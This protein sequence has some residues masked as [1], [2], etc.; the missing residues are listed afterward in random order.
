MR[1]A[2]ALLFVVALP[3]AADFRDYR[4]LAEDPAL[5]QGLASIAN[6]TLAENPNL[7]RENLSMTLIDLG[8]GRRASF[9]P[10]VG[11]HPASVVKLF[12]LSA[13]YERIRTGRLRRSSELDRAMRDMIVDSA[14]D[15]TSY[16]IDAISGVSSGPELA[17]R[18]FRRWKEKREWVTRFFA[19]QGYDI[20]AA[21]K[22]WAEGPYGR[23]VQLL[24][25][26]R[27][28]RNRISSEQPA[29]LI[30][31]IVNGRA[32]SKKASEEMLALMS[33]DVDAQKI[34][35]GDNQVKEFLGESLPAGSKLWSKAGWTSEVRHDA[36]L[37]ELPNG[38]RF[39]AVVLTRGD[40]KN[41]ALLPSIGRKLVALFQ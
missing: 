21:G 28:T 25:A 34:A 12:F 10:E 37:V 17:G 32:V 26:N 9:Q 5:A 19:A 7:K 29:A 1:F 15:A 24:G 2:A 16:V 11:Y 8:A 33:R 39:I 22:T 6:A 3:A 27:E 40:A 30:L 13:A 4:A 36:A 35:E 18:A 31:D 14:N 23:E 20:R 38:R 41:T